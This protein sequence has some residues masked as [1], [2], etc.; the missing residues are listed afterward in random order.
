M[1]RWLDDPARACYCDEAERYAQV[2][3][4]RREIPWRPIVDV[5]LPGESVPTFGCASIRSRRANPGRS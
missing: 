3:M 2:H 4:M 1:Y 5:P